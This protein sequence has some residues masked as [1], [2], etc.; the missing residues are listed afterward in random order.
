MVMTNTYNKYQTQLTEEY[1]N[2]LNPEVKEKLFEYI[3]TVPFIQNLISPDRK[4]AKDLPR[5]LEGKIIVDICNPHILEDMD[6]FR[7]MAIHFEEH[8]CYTK[9]RPNPNPNSEFGLLIRR[10]INRILNGMVRPEDGEWIT[11]EFYF[12]L[13]YTR[14]SLTKTKK[15]QKRADRVESFPEVWEG[16]YLWFHYLHQA[17]F[18]GLYDNNIGGKQAAMIARRGAGKRFSLSAVLARLFVTGDTVEAREKVTGVITAYAKGYLTTDGTLNKFITTIDFLAE[19]CPFFPSA[20]IK[21]SLQEMDWIIGYKDANTG[22]S[23]G[24]RNEII[25]FSAKDNPDKGRG[26]RAARFIFEEFGVFPRFL[27]TWNTTFPSVKEGEY[28]YGQMIAL[29]TGGTENAD[30]SGALELIYHPEGYDV[31]ALPNPFDSNVPPGGTSV[32]FF[33]S[34]LNQKGYYNKD[35]VSDVIGALVS[36]LK[37]RVRIKYNSSDPNTLAQRIAELAITIKE[38]VLKRDGAIYPVNDL[39]E[40]LAELESTPNSFNRLYVGDLSLNGVDVKFNPT[41]DVI[42]ITEFPH[43]S[44]KHEGAVVIYELPVK[45]SDGKVLR[46]RYIAG[47]DPYDDDSSDTLSLGALYILDLW[48][49]KL[50][51]EYVGRPLFADDFYEIVRR[52]LLFYNAECNYENNKKGVFKYFSQYNSVYLLSPTLDFL[53][54]KQMMRENM[55]GN[56]A[57]GTLATEP[58]KSYARRCLKNWLLKPVK[59]IAVVKGEDDAAREEEVTVR[60]LS[61]IPFKPL[62]QELIIW[63][64]DGNFDRHD[65]LAMLMLLREDKLRLFGEGMKKHKENSHNGSD[66][67][68]DNFF[69][70]NYKIQS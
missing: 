41:A 44:N 64:P 22:V 8:G 2:S 39:S 13:N 52:C 15:G 59:S 5:D 67:A 32:F 46:G 24:L 62:L 50:V 19:N 65:A 51:L 30:F 25:G 56:K 6:Y 45:G 53:K 26:K 68:N 66:L 16:L 36:E 9:L 35:G 55:Y 27:N 21:D 57:Y 42:P 20:R 33:G 7:E 10:E 23:K 70:K 48:T 61:F 37:A 29:G 4:Y 17:R 60:N 40:R 49:D 14:M 69:N 28:S 3:N 31:Y 54:E 34:Y 43:K 47:L 63:N 18:G 58:I 12:F 1:L 11:G 38:A